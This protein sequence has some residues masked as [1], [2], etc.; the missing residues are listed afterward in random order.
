METKAAKKRILIS[1]DDGPSGITREICDFLESK[2]LGAL[3]FL[4][5]EHLEALLD[6]AVY[7][8]QKGMVLGNHSYSHQAFSS[9]SFEAGVHEIEKT[10]SLINKVYKKAGLARPAKVFRFP[11]G[12]TGT[13]HFAQFQDY[14][15]KEGFKTL[16]PPHIAYDWYEI[17]KTQARLDTFWTVDT[18]DYQ[19]TDPQHNYSLGDAVARLQE[20]NPVLGGSLVQG[21]SDEILLMHDNPHTKEKYPDYYKTL[22]ETCIDLELDFWNPLEAL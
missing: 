6:T 11:Y 8:A 3:M 10:E 16:N 13:E 22:I 17:D 19:F 5:G 20:K 21:S 7:A 4:W 15:R 9:L 2:S 1:L 12:D 18:K 14:L